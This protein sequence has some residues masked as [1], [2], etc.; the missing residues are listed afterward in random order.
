VAEVH[1]FEFG[2]ISPVL[3]ALSAMFGCLLG[4]I[5]TT[6]AHKV[7]G[8][9][10]VRLLAYATVAVGVAGVWQSNVLALMGL[11]V[12][13]SVLRLDPVAV[14]ASLG[15]AIVSV[16]AGL[17]L[18]GYGGVGFLR[19]VAAGGLIGLGVA[20]THFL[21]VGSVRIGGVVTYNRPLL[22]ASV[23]M[24]MAAACALL[25]FLLSLRGL[26]AAVAAAVVSGLAIC[27]VHYVG[28]YA[29]GVHLGPVPG[30]LPE[31]ITG[32]APM[33]LILPTMV[34]G[35]VL[36]AM[37]WFF[38][39]GTATVRDL[40]AVFSATDH[41]GQ[42]EP[43]IIEAV[44]RRVGTLAP[45]PDEATVAIHPAASRRS[46]LPTVVPVFRSIH[47]PRTLDPYAIPEEPTRVNMIRI[48]PTPAGADTGRTPTGADRGTAPAGA[49][50]GLAPAGAHGGEA[51][52]TWPDRVPVP[53]VRT[54]EPLRAKDRNTRQPIDTRAEDRTTTLR[55]VSTV[56][57]E[58]PPTSVAA[59][60][61]PA[62]GLPARH[63]AATLADVPEAET[64]PRSSRN[65]RRD[66]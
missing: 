42:I 43:W 35:G 4:I 26:S 18:V 52:M 16:G 25:W 47:V 34:F 46:R 21:I 55:R 60:V 9:R 59:P 62:P 15:L 31:P 33:T 56:H 14:V 5:L 3:A 27:G 1:H 39:V 29:I 23:V 30:R 12:P 53:A 64:R 54:P 63:R 24:A 11:G 22:V 45:G 44:V 49:Q 6:K 20:G 57:H 8:G 17:Y 32:V 28:Q 48:F 61:S 51:P 65:R 40:R 36:I 41:S 13:G 37:L 19:L 50:R 66:G 10:R 58:A 2:P 38:T 7:S